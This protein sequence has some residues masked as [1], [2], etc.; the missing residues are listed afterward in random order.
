MY[1]IV[2]MWGWDNPPN[3]PLTFSEIRKVNNNWENHMEM[4]SQD[5][6]GH[7]AKIIGGL[8]TVDRI[9]QTAYQILEDGSLLYLGRLETQLPPPR[10][11][12][13][14]NNPSK[15]IANWLSVLEKPE[16]I[17]EYDEIEPPEVEF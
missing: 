11:V 7:Q 9:L 3:S 14:I 10:K 2:M 1:A 12:K 6:L 16:A 15:P 5:Y 17:L 4:W 13:V 8:K